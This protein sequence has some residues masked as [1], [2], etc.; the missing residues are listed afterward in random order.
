[1]EWIK[2]PDRAAVFRQTRWLDAGNLFQ[3]DAQV[4]CVFTPARRF[5][6]ELLELLHEDH[7]LEL[8]HAIVAA[9]G[10]IRLGAFEA[11]RGVSDVVEGVAAVEKF[12]AVAG[13]GAAFAGRDMLGILKAETRQIAECAAF[14]AFVFGEPGLASILDHRKL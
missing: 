8:L 5:L 11:S 6:H 3:M 2:V 1:S 10:K 4:V 13:H 7:G 14:A 9:T 12:I